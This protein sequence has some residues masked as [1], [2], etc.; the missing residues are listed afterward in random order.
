M[1]K[2]QKQQILDL[3][4]TLHEAHMELKKFFSAGQ[5]Q[6]VFDILSACQESAVQI[7][8]FIEETEGE[9]AKTVHHIEDYCE[10]LY[11]VSMEI[12]NLQSDINFYKQLQ[13]KLHEIENS[14][15]EDIKTTFE[16]LFLPYKASMWDSF[17]SIWLGAKEDPSCVV[18]IVPVPYYE[19][20]PDGTFGKMYY[21]GAEF[22]DESVVITNWREYDV[23]NHHPDIIYTHYPYDNNAN[24]AS[25]HPNFYSERLRK[26][27]DLLVYVP[28]F[29]AIWKTVDEYN[30]YLPGV[31]YA[32]KVIVQSEA[33]RQS[34]IR[35]YKKF[36]IANNLNERFGRAERKFVALGSP[37]FD[38]VINTRREDL[39]LS[40]EWIRLI[41]KPNGSKKKFI[42]YNT[43]MFTWLRGGET[44]FN[45]LLDVFN[46]FKNRDDVVLWWRPHPNTELNFRTKWPQKL[47]AYR[48]LVETYKR[49]SFGIY[50]DS[51][52]LNRAIAF[53]DAYYGDWSSLVA[54]YLFSG[55]PMMVQNIDIM[56]DNKALFEAR[57]DAFQ[58]SIDDY[59]TPFQCVYRESVNARL[60]DFLD[61]I[62][63]DNQKSS[64]ALRKKQLELCND[65]TLHADGTAGAE[66]FKYCNELILRRAF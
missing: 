62:V 10:L 1:R 47:K 34:Y 26:H 13:K 14:I 53:S 17:E 30:G 58:R 9:E 42:L 40:D 39:I 24:N 25:I 56:E 6:E 59:N 4:Q 28:Y 48:E 44:Y 22:Y 52:D 27:C 3:I 20:N 37:K 51:A 46:S 7:G 49:E 54:L 15:A 63:S 29:V 21:E 66:I 65:L 33:V 50:D 64:S 12:E 5:I 41:E 57:S 45:K 55:N 32:H 38:K 18:F 16:V 60:S 36:D 19:L 23:E 11:Q 35:H 2:H 61:F 31:L 8:K 43:H